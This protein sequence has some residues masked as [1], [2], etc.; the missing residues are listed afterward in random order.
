MH[1]AQ[2]WKVE[3][4]LDESEGRT[5]AR[6]E[7][8]SRDR[9]LTGRG[10]ARCRPGDPDVPEIGDELATARALADL[11]HQLIDAAITDVA[12]VAQRGQWAAS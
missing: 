3:V 11:S 8:R 1:H 10:T 2:T 6:A 4:F 7:L 9:T 12:S 5:H